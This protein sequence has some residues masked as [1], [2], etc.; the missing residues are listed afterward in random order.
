MST[1]PML[2]LDGY[3]DIPAGKIAM[4]VTFLEML[5]PPNAPLSRQRPDL[6]LDRWSAPTAEAYT[7]LFR[8]IGEDWIWC[9]R[10]T[11]NKCA[12][13]TI[14]SEPTR[15]MFR[16]MIDGK[17]A[18]LLEIDYANLAEPEL[19]YFGLTPGAIGG[20]VGRW[21]M[22]QAVEMVWSRP[23]T[24]RF[25]LHTCTADSPQALGFYMS[26]GFKPCKR[27]IEV[28]DDPRLKGIYDADKAPH[29]PV[30]D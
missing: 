13:E 30:I 20:G 29:V 14:L 5:A 9:E 25:W 1:Q 11:M 8:E 18:G 27:A 2:D 21:L 15:E 7:S 24:K 19:A 17:P 23:D 16:A 3:T 6:V 22:G 10:L 12:L 28:T 4:V 26:C